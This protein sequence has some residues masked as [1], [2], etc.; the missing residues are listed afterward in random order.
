MLAI[1]LIH[2]PDDTESRHGVPVGTPA[3]EIA[4]SI[5]A[6]VQDEAGYLDSGMPITPAEVVVYAFHDGFPGPDR[7]LLDAYAAA[8]SIGHGPL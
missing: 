4:E 3:D 7:S 5:L 1:V 2:I 8:C 6:R